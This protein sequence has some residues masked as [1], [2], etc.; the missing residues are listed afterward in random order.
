MKLIFRI[1]EEKN[2]NSNTGHW[3]DGQSIKSHLLSVFPSMVCIVNV[4]TYLKHICYG[5]VLS[6]YSKHLNNGFVRF[7]NGQV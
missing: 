7:S 6:K 3:R 2:T 5:T 4:R 1:Y